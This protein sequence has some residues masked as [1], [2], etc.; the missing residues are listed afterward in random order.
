MQ[1]EDNYK[2]EINKPLRGSNRL[3]GFVFGLI[4]GVIVVAIEIL[5]SSPSDF[6][7]TS[8]IIYLLIVLAFGIVG[9]AFGDKFIEKLTEWL[10]W[11]C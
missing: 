8:N 6:H 9:A 10:Q 11:F 4:I 3:P 5:K 1:S 7:N 2:D